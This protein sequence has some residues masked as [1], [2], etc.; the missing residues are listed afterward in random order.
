LLKL[1]VPVVVFIGKVHARFPSMTPSFA[2]FE[3]WF[4]ENV[5]YS[6]RRGRDQGEG[7]V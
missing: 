1:P 7:D 4:P 2:S 6:D 5:R 3:N